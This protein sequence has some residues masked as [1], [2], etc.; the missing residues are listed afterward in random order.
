MR[1]DI[2][3]IL[4]VGLMQ[5]PKATVNWFR[6]YAAIQSFQGTNDE[7]YP[8]LLK[9]AKRAFPAPKDS[10]NAGAW[11]GRINATSK[12]IQGL[13]SAGWIARKRR[14]NSSNIYRCRKS[15]S[16]GFPNDSGVGF[17]ND[18]GTKT[19]LKTPV[20]GGPPRAPTLIKQPFLA[21]ARRKLFPAAAA[22]LL[23]IAPFFFSGSSETAPPPG[24]RG[25]TGT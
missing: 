6:V 24:G 16:S 2:Y 21:K 22:A 8:S 15:V 17:P 9:I 13:A 23:L 20:Q 1:Q 7:A 12:A 25:P 5:D 14:R 18:S 3:G 19:P 11:K 10:E 4:P